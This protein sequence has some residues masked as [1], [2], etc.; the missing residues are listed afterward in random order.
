MTI[1][2]IAENTHEIYRIQD[3]SPSGIGYNY[4]GGYKEENGFRWI[5]DAT[6]SVV[7]SGGRLMKYDM[8]WNLLNT[9]SG[10]DFADVI[11]DIYY[12]NNRYYIC[13]WS[14]GTGLKAIVSYDLDM[15]D[16]IGYDTYGNPMKIIKYK[17]KW[18][19][20]HMSTDSAGYYI[21]RF[22]A[23]E[24]TGHFTVSNRSLFSNASFD[25][26]FFTGYELSGMRNQTPVFNIYNNELLI[27]GIN[28][29]ATISYLHRFNLELMINIDGD[30]VVPGDYYNRYD[31]NSLQIPLMAHYSPV[32]IDGHYLLFV[33]H[34]TF[35]NNQCLGYWIIDY[36]FNI[37]SKIENFNINARIIDASN[38]EIIIAP[39]LNAFDM[40][41]K[42]IL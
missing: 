9:Y 31:S 37:I 13:R 10:G 17:N 38:K 15:T 29:S 2:A 34:P 28:S 42:K 40:I 16:R 3:N 12:Y 20:I 35:S 6:N 19:V 27:Q 4:F 41:T 26:K 5:W 22:D 32:N 11:S 30:P 7:T 25:N 18:F 23:D 24:S 14:V 1:K 36:D 39:G 8:E 33:R 21:E